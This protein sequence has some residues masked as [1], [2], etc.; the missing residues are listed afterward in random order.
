M[1]YRCANCDHEWNS[2]HFVVRFTVTKIRKVKTTDR[3]GEVIDTPFYLDYTLVD[4]L[5][6]GEYAICKDRQSC[7]QRAFINSLKEKDT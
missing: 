7:N 6:Q 4:R 3:I 2:L 5:E 1:M